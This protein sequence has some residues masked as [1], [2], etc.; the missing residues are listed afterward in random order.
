MSGSK[1][2]KAKRNAARKCGLLLLLFF[3]ALRRSLLLQ[4]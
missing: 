4:E 2:I 3:L 1:K